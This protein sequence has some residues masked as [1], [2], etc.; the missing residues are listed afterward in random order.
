MSTAAGKPAASS[1]GAVALGVRWK[2]KD[3]SPVLIGEKVMEKLLG[4]PL[5]NWSKQD[6]RDFQEAIRMSHNHLQPTP[7]DKERLLDDASPKMEKE[8]TTPSSSP[9]EIPRR[10]T[11]N[12][13]R[14]NATVNEDESVFDLEGKR[15]KN[16][17]DRYNFRANQPRALAEMVMFTLEQKGIHEWTTADKTDYQ[18][19]VKIQR[20]L[21]SLQA[22][23]T[24]ADLT[25]SSSERALA[26]HG[27][28]MLLEALG[29]L[30]DESAAGSEEVSSLLESRKPRSRSPSKRRSRHRSPTKR[31]SSL[32]S[33]PHKHPVSHQSS[34][35]KRRNSP[36]KRHAS[37]SKG[38]SRNASP[39]KGSPRQLPVNVLAGAGEDEDTAGPR[40][41]ASTVEISLGTLAKLELY[42]RAVFGPFFNGED[43]RQ[44]HSKLS[45]V[46]VG[47]AVHPK[48]PAKAS[49]IEDRAVVK[50]FNETGQVP[51]LFLGI[52]D[53]HGGIEFHDAASPVTAGSKQG[54]P[55]ESTSAPAK[56]SRA[57]RKNSLPSKAVLCCAEYVA[58]ELPS[59]VQEK[60]QRALQQPGRSSF[61]HRVGFS[62][63]PRLTPSSE[64]M[65]YRSLTSQHAGMMPASA[66]H[67]QLRDAITRPPLT[68]ASSDSLSSPL[69]DLSQLSDS[70]ATLMTT[71]ATSQPL[72][73]SA[74]SAPLPASSPPPL[75]LPTSSPPLPLPASSPPPLSSSSFSAGTIPDRTPSSM[76]SNSWSAAQP[77]LFHEAQTSKGSTRNSMDL[78]AIVKEACLELDKRFLTMQMRKA[79]SLDRDL[80]GTTAIFV[81]TV[82]NGLF[83]QST[84]AVCLGDSELVV[85]DTVK[86]SQSEGAPTVLPG[87][88]N[89]F[90][91]RSV[92]DKRMHKPDHPNETQRIQAG[93]GSVSKGRLIY[94]GGSQSVSRS[95]GDIAYKCRGPLRLKSDLVSPEPAVV[96]VTLDDHEFLLL[97]SDGLWDYLSYS[98][99]VSILH[100]DL[101]RVGKQNQK[102]DLQKTCEKIVAECVVR[103]GLP[104]NKANDDISLCVLWLA[105]PPSD[106]TRSVK[107]ECLYFLP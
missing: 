33:S 32:Q 49:L 48:D 9:G 19:C 91:L 8:M 105:P 99:V 53:G 17:Q 67:E 96:E 60:M 86:D 98:D 77:S 37:P 69:G 36:H 2:V 107:P 40:E 100:T 66:S 41:R 72:M 5:H 20:K 16:L 22:E 87:G 63:A 3:Q 23:K 93:G 44:I 38:K 31:P 25:R 43:L 6:K 55:T 102:A 76:H 21:K 10:N 35:H 95:F 84:V 13:K 80:S 81:V 11:V 27:K 103:Q 68:S 42:E 30:E 26:I 51:M 83:R 79:R 57:Q 90:D 24:A 45:N 56:S 104:S 7:T 64:A 94:C 70:F 71:L 89:T 12:A 59:L 62:R 29:A 73:S 75:P 82:P 28:S 4:K 92:F 14:L 18:T 88:M 52:F 1:A 46:H 74:F 39:K 61:L 78:C 54:T 50:V 101:K 34:P 65:P 85:V 58:H 15:V 47:R 106:A 97:G